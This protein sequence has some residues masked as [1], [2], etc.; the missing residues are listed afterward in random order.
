MHVMAFTF[1][2]GHN[3]IGFCAA[4][5]CCL[6][7]YKMFQW[8]RTNLLST[9]IGKYFHMP[10][11]GNSPVSPRFLKGYSLSKSNCVAIHDWE[12]ILDFLTTCYYILMVHHQTRINIAIVNQFSTVTNTMK[13]L[14]ATAIIDAKNH[15]TNAVT[16]FL[17]FM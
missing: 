5:T 17:G 3:C 8:Y 2:C 14:I 11:P 13:I 9:N 15:S 16:P 1:S 7:V 6:A 12:H 4:L 10:K